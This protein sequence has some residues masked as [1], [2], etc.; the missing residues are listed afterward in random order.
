MSVVED[1]PS[2]EDIKKA[3]IAIYY[4]KYNYP[5]INKLYDIM[6]KNKIN[7]SINDIKTFIQNQEESQL[8]QVPS[9][10]K[11][12]L[13]HITAQHKNEFWQMDIFDLS[14]YYSTNKPYK[15]ILCCIDVFTRFAYCVPIES[16]TI[17]DVLA[18]FKQIVARKAKSVPNVITS[19]TDST[20]LSEEFQKLVKDLGIKSKPSS[21][22]A[23]RHF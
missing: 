4:E 13:G 8:L 22:T 21:S 7:V 9:E 20:F 10:K 16:K 2:S 17:S 15:Y 12:A 5:G 11:S 14:K 23:V 6:K 3:E 18:A 1:Q 19:D